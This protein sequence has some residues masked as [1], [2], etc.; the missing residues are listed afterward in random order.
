[1]PDGFSI[2]KTETANK[3]IFIGFDCNIH[4]D[5]LSSRLSTRLLHCESL[6]ITG[7]SSNE[8]RIEQAGLNNFFNI[9]EVAKADEGII[10]FGDKVL[11]N[12]RQ[13]SRCLIITLN[14][15][16]FLWCHFKI[17]LATTNFILLNLFSHSLI[18]TT[19]HSTP[20]TNITSRDGFSIQ[21]LER[22]AD[23]VCRKGHDVS[24]L[25]QLKLL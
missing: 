4:T 21:R 19:I 11:L 25:F 23:V 24:G 20:S 10:F 18:I 6:T 1:M 12:S 15:F 8:C 9:T 13:S 17:P 7:E 14:L 2:N 5:E 3:I 22:S 16:D